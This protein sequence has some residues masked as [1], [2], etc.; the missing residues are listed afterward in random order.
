MKTSYK[1]PVWKSYKFKNGETYEIAQA[2]KNGVLVFRDCI[3]EKK[4]DKNW[5][6]IWSKS[7]LKKW[8]EKWWKNNAPDE[9][10]D[11]FK[12]DLLAL[13]EIF[14]DKKLEMFEDWH[15]R[16]KGLKGEETSTWWWTKTACRG[17]AYAAYIVGATGAISSNRAGSAHGVAPACRPIKAK[18]NDNR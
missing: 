7:S 14:G 8:L 9:L 10:K 4:F 15:N 6:N 16:I 5:S 2:D 13:E 18:R 3:C 1:N 11:N 12:V 17:Y